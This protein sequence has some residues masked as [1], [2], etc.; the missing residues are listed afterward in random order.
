MQHLHAIPTQPY[1]PQEPAEVSP[2][3]ENTPQTLRQRLASLWGQGTKPN[4]YFLIIIYI[5][6]FVVLITTKGILEEKLHWVMV[7][8]VLTLG[9]II[10]TLCLMRN[11]REQ[12]L[13]DLEQAHTAHREI[14][15]GSS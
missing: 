12:Q 4:I 9:V 6:L 1:Q 14:E 8:V 5:F 10:G 3:P 13:R 11:S 7:F 2:T 15:S